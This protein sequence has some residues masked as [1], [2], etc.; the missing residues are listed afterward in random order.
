MSGIDPAEA[1]GELPAVHAGH[2]EVGE[3]HVEAARRVG[4]R[5][6]V[7]PLAAASPCGRRC[8]GSRPAS[9]STLGSSSTSSTRRRAGAPA[10]ARLGSVPPGSLATGNVSVKVVPAARL[11]VHADLAAVAPDDRVDHRQAE[12]GAALA[13]RREERLED[14]P[15]HRLRHADA[16]VGHR[17]DARR[18]R[19]SCARGDRERAAVRHGVHGVE[20]Q[21][22]HH[23]GQR[24]RP[25]VDG[26]RSCPRS[27]RRSSGAV[28]ARDLLLPAGPD[29]GDRVVHDLVDVDAPRTAR[30][31]A[32]ARTAGCAAPSRSRPWPPIRP[33]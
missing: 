10:A 15:A 30:R 8:A 13:L 17:H 7:A 5:A 16:G 19:G 4:R 11:A 29:D 28:V 26:A 22:G 31:A 27:S 2:A 21:V 24:G 32:A 6:P 1:L 9:P 33:P 12:P 14:A 25:A 23:L 18:A 20:D 3:H